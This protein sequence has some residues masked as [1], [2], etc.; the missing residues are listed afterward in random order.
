M[1]EFLNLAN[2]FRGCPIVDDEFPLH[3]DRFDLALDYLTKNMPKIICLC[4]ST[5]FWT[6]FR[7]EGL[8]LTL[9]GAIVLSIGICDPISM[10][11]AHP[12]SAAGYFIK[13]RLD[14]LHKRKIDLA[15][16]ILVLNVGGYIDDSTRSE[17][18]YARAAGKQVIFLESEAA[19]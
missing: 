6:T 18:L 7:N 13:Q 11:H 19:G 1:R 5:R 12:D 4:G 14:I 8:R 9:E 3:R 16:E 17:I 2:E 10:A 15:D